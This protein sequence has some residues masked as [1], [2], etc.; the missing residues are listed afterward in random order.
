MGIRK[1]VRRAFFALATILAFAGLTSYF[2]LA[3]LSNSSRKVVATGAESVRVS[4]EILDLSV[5]NNKIFY[6][7]SQNRDKRDLIILGN[8]TLYSLDSISIS[9]MRNLDTETHF[10]KIIDDIDQYKKGVNR[11]YSAEY[12]SVDNWY[13]IFQSEVYLPFV[14]SIKQYM[15]YSQKFVVEETTKIDDGIYRS[16]MLGVVA[17]LFT[18]AILAIF[19]VLLDI[20]YLKPVVKLTKSLDEYIVSKVPFTVKVDGRDEVYKLKELILDL[21]SANKSANKNNNLFNKE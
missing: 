21:I 3:N 2:E 9:A 8:K 18:I 7:Y 14:K 11:F 20:Y 16:I 15:V 5:L 1:R 6:D 13:Y 10:N 19:F 12:N 4:T 17:M